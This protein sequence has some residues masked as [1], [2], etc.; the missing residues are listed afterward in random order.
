MLTDE[1]LTYLFDGQPH[2]LAEAM[3]VWLKSSRR[4]TAFVTS[5]RDKIRKKIRVT[6]DQETFYDLQLELETAYRLLQ[7]R[8]LSVVYE[9]EQSGPGRSPDFAVTYTTSLTFMVEVTRLRAVTASD[10][11]LPQENERLGDAICSKLR[12]FLPQRG[13]VLIVGVD[14]L[15]LTQTDLQSLM[16]RIQQRAERSDTA[17]WQRYGFRERADFFQAYQRLSEILVRPSQFQANEPAIVWVNPRAR[18][19]LPSKIRTAL[20]RSH[21]IEL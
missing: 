21:S 20:H 18:H 1:L 9:P 7:E 19:P 15:A 6:R 11:A 10:E 12:Q 13:N 3:D 17:F 8:T 5:F 14:A 4:F 2:I 16:L